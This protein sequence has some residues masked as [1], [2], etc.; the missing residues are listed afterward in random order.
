[1]SVTTS[2]SPRL[3]AYSS[4]YILFLSANRFSHDFNRLSNLETTWLNLNRPP[5]GEELH[6]TP[7]QHPNDLLRGRG[8]AKRVCRKLLEGV[9]AAKERRDFWLGIRSFP[10]PSVI[11]YSQDKDA[12]PI[13]NEKVTNI[14]LRSLSP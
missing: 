8:G 10:S 13:G 2:P 6:T 1:M 3:S 5:H 7:P 11:L 9:G 14:R 4:H 12:N